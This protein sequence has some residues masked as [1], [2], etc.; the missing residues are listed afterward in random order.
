MQYSSK[1]DGLINNKITPISLSLLEH[2]V[3]EHSIDKVERE[4]WRRFSWSSHRVF[5]FI[6]FLLSSAEP[7]QKQ[8]QKQKKQTKFLFSPFY[9]SSGARITATLINVLR[10][11]DGKIGVASI[12][13]GGGGASAIVIERL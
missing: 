3:V 10:Q 5:L 13:N 12:C 7:F 6:P 1:I 8:K 11:K 9:R 4:R 2:S